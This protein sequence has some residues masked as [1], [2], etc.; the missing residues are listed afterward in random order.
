VCVRDGRGVALRLGVGGAFARTGQRALCQNRMA[1]LAMMRRLRSQFCSAS[2]AL[3]RF[4]AKTLWALLLSSQPN[5]GLS[6][7]RHQGERAICFNSCAG[8]GG[9]GAQLPLLETHLNSLFCANSNGLARDARMRALAQVH[10]VGV[11]SLGATS[12]KGDNCFLVNITSYTTNPIMLYHHF[13]LLLLDYTYIL[14]PIMTFNGP[15][16]TIEC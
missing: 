10:S 15:S 7:L 6:E 9:G 12:V 3:S 11:G 16:K 2:S 13:I 14:S 8:G 1:L 4:E 5:S